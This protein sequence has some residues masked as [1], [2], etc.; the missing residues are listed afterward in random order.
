MFYTI[1][2]ADIMPPNLTPTLHPVHVCSLVAEQGLFP[3]L[4]N[5]VMPT[6][7]TGLI[8]YSILSPP[9]LMDREREK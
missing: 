8:F 5:C 2:M 4:G 9:D 1:Y 3:T 6:A 7:R